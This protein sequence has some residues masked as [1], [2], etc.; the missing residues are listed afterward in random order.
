MGTSAPPGA[1]SRRLPPAPK[2][3]AVARH[4]ARSALGE[5]APGLRATAELLVGELVTNAV[6]HARGEVEVRVWAAEGR[7]HARISDPRPDRGLVPH[8]RRP[9]AGTGRGLSLVEELATSYGVHSGEDHKTVWFELWPAPPAPPTSAWETVGPCGRTVT[10]ALDD[11]P[12]ALYWA[13]QQQWE[14]ALRELL[15]APAVAGRA[16]ARPKD[17][18]AAQEMS[19]VISACMTAAVKRETPDTTTL[20]L[21][22]TFPADAAPAAVA[23]GQVLDR[24]D[25][26]ARR[27]DLLVLPALPQIRAFRRWLLSQISGQLSG[28]QP[29]AWTL[30]TGPP[31]AT[32]TKLAPWD[33]S[34]VEA[35]NVPTIAADDGNRIIA[36][37]NSAAHLLGWSP[38][39]LVGRR[40]TALI[41]EH[42]RER[43]VAGFNSLLLTGEP[44]ILGRSIPLPALHREGHVV[45]VRLAVQTQE[46]IDGR[47]VFV[48]QLTTTTA[49]PAPPYAPPGSRYATRPAPGPVHL[50]TATR[51]ARRVTVDRAVSEWLPLFADTSAALNSTPDLGE[52]MRRVCH[53]LTQWLAEWCAV[54][55]L[56]HGEVERA[57]IVH[58]DPHLVIPGGH[59]GRLPPITDTT[60]AP[61]PRVLGGAGPLLVT[62][63]PVPGRTDNPMDA[64]QL[65]LVAQLGGSTAVIAPLRGDQEVFG[66]LTLVRAEAEPPFTKDDIPLVAELVRGIAVGLDNARQHQNSHANAEQLQR[67]LL[68]ELPRA[69][70]LELVARYVP[71][72]TTAKIGGDWYDAFALPRGD[73]VLVIG[74]VSGHDLQAAVAMSTLRNM[75]RGLAVDHP[76]PPGDVLRR[77]DLASH[78]LSPRSTATC[79]YALLKD[80]CG[81]GHLD[82]HHSSAG[83]LPPLLTTR[84]GDA[85][86]LESGRGLLIGMDPDIPRPSACD[87]LPPRSTLLL[88]TDGLVERRGQSLD[89][90]LNHL[91]EYAATLARDSLDVFCDELIIKFGGDATD[92]IALL[93]L[94]P[95]GLPARPPAERERGA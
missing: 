53:V 88:F 12:Y 15:L 78:T 66:A 49:G 67:A 64:R 41:P 40:L 23:L 61:L 94:R 39:D 7:V 34:E 44:R 85:R 69:G 11:V 24:A 80:A 92:D 30:V 8:D 90:G 26:A 57:C 52:R 43:H 71:S 22:V 10:V 91:R 25:M 18:L 4:F 54:D 72:S 56:D 38:H 50:P 1:P 77:L 86:Y 14:G 6:I 27:G 68:P 45:P 48:A 47:S 70:H 82:L 36:V 60:K 59:L 87:P 29:T 83:H 9:Y 76:E 63:I 21:A 16:G 2:S 37:N 5:V 46:A 55:L 58:R 3:A 19:H 93:A 35:A 81:T 42:L 89:I 51:K 28:R 62:D 84:E 65:E 20:S 33:A 73:I 17:L 95:T 74:D 32:P 31:G 13:A 79:V 75:L